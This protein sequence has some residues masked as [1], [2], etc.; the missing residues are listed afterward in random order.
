MPFCSRCVIGFL[1]LERRQRLAG[2]IGRSPSRVP[3]HQLCAV[4]FVVRIEPAT[5]T[6]DLKRGV[7]TRSSTA[8]TTVLSTVDA[9]SPRGPCVDPLARRISGPARGGVRTAYFNFSHP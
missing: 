9:H 6:K 3:G 5:M 2:T 8:T 1:R 4:L 7:L